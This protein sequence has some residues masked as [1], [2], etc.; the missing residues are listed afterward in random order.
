M[1]NW[2][3]YFAPMSEVNNGSTTYPFRWPIRL[4][5]R[6]LARRQPR[7]PPPGGRSCGFGFPEELIGNKRHKQQ[8]LGGGNSNIFCFH[9]YLGKWSNLSNIFQMGWNHQLE[10]HHQPKNYPTKRQWELRTARWFFFGGW[11]TTF[12][13]KKWTWFLFGTDPVSMDP[14]KTTKLPNM[15]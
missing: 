15:T 14:G 13:G 6:K 11:P 10:K 1:G 7:R 12:K 2:G 4:T 3:V 5:S 9:P 8:K